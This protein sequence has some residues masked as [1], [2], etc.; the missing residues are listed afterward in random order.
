MH[1][2][3]TLRNCINTIEIEKENADSVVTGDD[4][5]CR[6]MRDEVIRYYNRKNIPCAIAL[7]GY[8]GAEWKPVVDQVTEMLKEVGLETVAIDAQE[9]YKPRE[10][11]DTLIEKYTESDPSLGTACTDKLLKDIMDDQKMSEVRE[12]ILNLK[13]TAPEKVAVI[14]CYGVGQRSSR[15]VRLWT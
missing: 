6:T 12:R 15:C 10:W 3:T 5:V 2:Y 8:F 11:I 1:W 7:D 13:K 14:F 4:N 9:L